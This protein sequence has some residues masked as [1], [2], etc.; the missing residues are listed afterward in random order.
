MD[1]SPAADLPDLYSHH[2][3]MV[4]ATCVCA[5]EGTRDARIY[6]YEDMS[7]PEVERFLPLFLIGSAVTNGLSGLISSWYVFLIWSS[8]YLHLYSPVKTNNGDINNTVIK[9]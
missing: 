3:T 9:L 2:V 6:T 5:D 7:C 8:R 4:N 1:C